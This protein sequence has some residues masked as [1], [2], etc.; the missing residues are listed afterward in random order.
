LF[1]SLVID[2]EE[3]EEGGGG[4]GEKRRK[5]TEFFFSFSGTIK[6]F[7]CSVSIFMIRIEREYI[8]RI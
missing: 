7:L 6:R 4:G 3:E 2:Q 1:F 8:N 5:S